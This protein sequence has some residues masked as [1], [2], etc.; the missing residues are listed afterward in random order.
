MAN[1]KNAHIRYNIQDYC[2]RNKSFKFDETLR[3]LNEKIVELLDYDQCLIVAAQ[4]LE[5][6]ENHPKYNKLAEALI[7]FQDD[8]AE[9]DTSKILFYGHNEEYKGIKYLKPLYLAIKKKQV[10]QITF[11][12][13]K[14][15]LSATF[16]F[17][18]Q[19]LKQ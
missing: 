3:F 11:K 18:P 9:N 17:Y 4:L 13:F 1:S 19:I 10:L 16:Q 6:F 5:R 15:E 7:K 2:F 12:G 14:D 8:E